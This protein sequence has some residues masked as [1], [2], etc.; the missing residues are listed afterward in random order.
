MM[1]LIL[2]QPQKQMQ[3]SAYYRLV[4]SNHGAHNNPRILKLERK[5]EYL[6]NFEI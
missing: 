1:F 2:V 6:A 3:E 4:E 5:L